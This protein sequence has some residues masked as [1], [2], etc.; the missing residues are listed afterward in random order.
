MDATLSESDELLRSTARQIGTDFACESVAEYDDYDPSAA[1]SKL[2]KLGLLGIRRSDSQDVGASTLEEAIVVEA[3]AHSALAVPYLGG[4]AFVSGLLMAADAPDDTMDRLT[5][6]ELRCAIALTHDLST[7]W[8]NSTRSSE[9]PVAFDSAGANAAL[10]LESNRGVRLRAVALRDPLD[11]MDV[12][13]RLNVV[14]PSQRVDAGSLGGVIDPLAFD[15]MMSRFLVLLSA[16]LVGVMDAA[17]ETAVAYAATREQFGVPIATF[18]AIQHICADQLV[19]I[20]AA[21]SLTEY[22]A[23]ALDES[24]DDE[25]RMA[26]QAAKAFSS[27]AGRSVCEAAVQVHG[28][29]GFTW[30]YM[31]HV[32]LKRAITDGLVLGDSATHLESIA[33]ARQAAN[34]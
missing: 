30:D 34:R 8:K 32:Y 19:S 2:S 17:L 33:Q 22:A 6:G 1:W 31:A 28:G 13:R 27:R 26:A 14:D 24:N 21:R 18:Q 25:S 7:L 5:S 12:T 16:D 11:P 20:E 3:L 9:P 15:L 4:S 23:W 10:I 29:V